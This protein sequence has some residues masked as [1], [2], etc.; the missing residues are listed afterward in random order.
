MRWHSACLRFVLIEMA[1]KLCANWLQK[2]CSAI[3]CRDTQRQAGRT[4]LCQS[5]VQS[6]CVRWHAILY[7]GFL[8][9]QDPPQSSTWGPSTQ[10][11]LVSTL[12]LYARVQM[13]VH[14][15]NWSMDSIHWVESTGLWSIT[16]VSSGSLAL[17]V[18]PCMLFGFYR[19][20]RGSFCFFYQGRPSYWFS[21]AVQR[22]ITELIKHL[23][24]FRTEHFLTYNFLLKK[25]HQ[26]V[27]I[28]HSQ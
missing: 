20:F 15:L 19:H 3:S 7:F 28:L 14:L 12:F 27:N 11:H 9:L 24:V 17:D 26:L 2:H 23:A 22:N 4:L 10:V 5:P 21:F 6:I 18:A 25:V 16:A 13:F 8:Q 1:Q